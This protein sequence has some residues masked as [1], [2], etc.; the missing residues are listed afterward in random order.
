MKTMAQT[1][2]D[3]LSI[4]RFARAARL[5][6]K[7]LRLYDRLGLLQPACVDRDSSYRYYRPEQLQVARL[8]RLLREME[9]PLAMVQ[10]VLE[11]DAETAGAMIVAYER[12]FTRR[13]ELVRRA[14]EQ[15]KRYLHHKEVLMAF[16]VEVRHLSA[17]P[18]LSVTSRVKVG[19]L[20]AHIMRTL[21][22]LREYAAGQGAETASPPFGIYHGA[23]NHEDDGPIEV[24][25][26]L[27]R[28]LTSDGAIVGANDGE[29]EDGSIVARELEGGRA[30]V[31]WL[32]E[33]YCVFP[34]I[35]EGY[36]AAYD[37]IVENGYQIA[38]SPRELWL[39]AIAE[40]GPVEIVWPFRE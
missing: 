38:G 32:S 26:P 33:E 5:S 37:W 15:V 20:D 17:Q 2:Q 22:Q 30:A 10:D 16:Q 34:A 7:A 21:A 29:P 1:R 11:A 36:D 18:V 14:S 35:L 24:C 4:G 8:I 31:V 6:H 13:L 39:G 25:L 19:Q 9:M 3:L 27:Q 40:T 28:P 23:I 12:S